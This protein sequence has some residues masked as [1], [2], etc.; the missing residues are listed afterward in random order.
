MNDS[1]GDDRPSRDLDKMVNEKR[2]KGEGVFYDEVKVPVRLSLTPT[3]K[4]KIRQEADLIGFSISE[5]I[6]TL[7][8]CR[9]GM[10]IFEKIP[11]ESLLPKDDNPSESLAWKPSAGKRGRGE[12]RTYNEKK[13]CIKINL[14][15][16]L[17]IEVQEEADRL[18]IS[19]SGMVEGLFRKR[20]GLECVEKIPVIATKEIDFSSTVELINR[21]EKEA[22]DLSISASELIESFLRDRYNSENQINDVNIKD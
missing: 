13:Q 21:L 3:I 2:M 22:N 20:Y 17:R 4:G 14:T 18:R 12:R 11:Q 19:I 6:E 5:I 15:S 10:E 16:S 1:T 8:R 9:Y 7:F